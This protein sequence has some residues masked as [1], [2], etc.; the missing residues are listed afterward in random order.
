[1]QGGTNH[2]EVLCMDVS[3]FHLLLLL[4]LCSCY[5]YLFIVHALSLA[6]EH[7]RLLSVRIDDVKYLFL[8][9][10][11]IFLSF[12]SK[13]ERDSI[14]RLQTY[15]YVSLCKLCTCFIFSFSVLTY[16][17]NYAVFHCSHPETMV[18]FL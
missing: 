5:H 18:L 7:C 9:K 2:N 15:P 6:R 10:M 1:M 11:P 12:L 14:Y 17:A 4:I 16:Y 8:W 3:V 13:E